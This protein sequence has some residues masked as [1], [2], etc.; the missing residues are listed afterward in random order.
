MSLKI[1]RQNRFERSRQVAALLVLILLSACNMKMPPYSTQCDRTASSL[2][3]NNQKKLVIISFASS[4]HISQTGEGPLFA[5]VG[6]LEK[7]LNAKIA[8]A[9]TQAHFDAVRA[10][11]RLHFR[12]SRSN[13]FETADQKVD[14]LNSAKVAEFIKNAE[15]DLGLIVYDRFGWV[16]NPGRS[17]IANYAFQ[18]RS[19]IF[20]SKGKSIWEF[21]GKGTIHPP[22]AD[23][24]SLAHAIAGSAP[25][26]ETIV[27]AYQPFMT[28]YPEFICLL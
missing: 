24:D 10:T 26:A 20:N 23:A 22:P 7:E 12:L 11:M 8:R 14:F 28:H 2:L 27:Q 15:A 5:L 6:P 9:L 16:W 17:G 25:S 1:K 13:T 18:N 21:A 3:T 4:A 19:A